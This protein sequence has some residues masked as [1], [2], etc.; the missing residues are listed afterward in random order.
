MLDQYQQCYKDQYHWFAA[1]Y[2]VCRQ[3]IITMVY[4][5]N[6]NNGLYYFQTVCIIIVIIHVWIKPYENETLNVLDGIILLTIVL[7]INLNSFIFSRAT[8]ITI[9]VIMVIFPLFCSCIIYGR[10]IFSFI[11]HKSKYCNLQ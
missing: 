4:V 9:V 7:V 8:T 5:S 6:F 2:L 3:V 11:K 10:S 1:Y